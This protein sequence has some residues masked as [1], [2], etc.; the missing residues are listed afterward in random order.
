LRLTTNDRLAGTLVGMQVDDLGIDY[1]ERRN[2]HIEAVTLEH[3]RRV[4][5]RLYD[6]EALLVVVVGGARGSSG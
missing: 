3:A 2:D 4:A 6:P 5:A 1:L